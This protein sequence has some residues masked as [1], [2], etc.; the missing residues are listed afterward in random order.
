[1]SLTPSQMN[2]RPDVGAPCVQVRGV[3]IT[4]GATSAS[5]AI[6]DTYRGTAPNR[7]LL[8]ATAACYARLGTPDEGSAVVAAAGTG[9]LTGDVITLT[10]G[11]FSEAMQLT[12]ASTALVSAAVN[13]AG[14]GYVPADTITAAGGTFSTAAV[15]AVATTKV[16]AVPTVVNAGT[17]GT[18]GSATVTGTTGTGTKFQATVTI[19]AGG[20]I[21]SV[22]ALT[23]AGSYTVNPTDIANEPVTGGGLTGAVLA[24]VM[25]VATVTVDTAGSYTVEPAAFTQSATSGAGTGATF[26]TLVFGVLTVTV[27]DPG[28]YTVEP[29]NPVAQGST[30]GAGTDATFTVTWAI[31]AEA[32]D[33][34]IQPGDS[35]IV[36]AV[37]FDHVAAIQVSS[38][39]VLVVTPLEN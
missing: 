6:P 28:A 12:V 25:G 27:S 20:T 15:L 5:A 2:T 22:D 19:E 36:D 17:G 9:Y 37:G 23:V 33:M 11:T 32:G 38:A 34:L 39:G 13:A 14:S 35:R 4:T 1:M 26:N 24:V 21:Q 31:A 7:I 18:P 3:A 16:S 8:A 29:S 10:G 30:D